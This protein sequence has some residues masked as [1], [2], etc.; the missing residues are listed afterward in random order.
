MVRKDIQLDENLIA[1]RDENGK[2]KTVSGR[3]EFHQAVAIRLAER[4]RTIERGGGI[5][6]Q[7][8]ERL[9]L[10]ASR[11]ARNHDYMGEIESISIELDKDNP[12]TTSFSIDYTFGGTYTE[13]IN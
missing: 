8:K 10:S 4:V 7:T 2:F 13:M 12:G 9:K 3:D 1:E 6:N 11:V 5:N